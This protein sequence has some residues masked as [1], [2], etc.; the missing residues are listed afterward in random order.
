MIDIT[1]GSIE[2]KEK[3]RYKRSHRASLAIGF[4]RGVNG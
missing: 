2:R 3:S 4:G 1:A